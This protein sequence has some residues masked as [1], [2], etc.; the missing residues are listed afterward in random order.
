MKIVIG[1]RDE[2]TT[3]VESTGNDIRLEEGSP[4]EVKK[5]VEYYSRKTNTTGDQLLQ[6]LLSRL[7]G[8]WWATLIEGNTDRTNDGR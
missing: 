8:G 1:F 4:R 2:I 6:I 7:R 5:I 3:T